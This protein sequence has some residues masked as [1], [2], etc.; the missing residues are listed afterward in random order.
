MLFV[1]NGLRRS[2]TGLLVT[3]AFF[4]AVRF[5]VLAVENHDVFNSNFDQISPIA[6]IVQAL[7]AILSVLLASSFLA[8][9]LGFLSALFLLAYL[10]FSYCL[11]FLRSEGEDLIGDVHI[12]VA[13]A[14]TALLFSM[15]INEL[16]RLY[17]NSIEA[18]VDAA[19]D[20]FERELPSQFR[21]IGETDLYQNIRIESPECLIISLGGVTQI[22]GSAI[23]DV[24]RP[25]NYNTFNFV[26]IL[27]AL[28]FFVVLSLIV[29][30]VRAK[31]DNNGY[32]WLGY[33]SIAVFSVYLSLTA[34]LAV[35]LLATD[36]SAEAPRPGSELQ[37]AL[38][39][40]LPMT[41]VSA[42]AT[43]P[44]NT[45]EELLE[46]RF[47]VEKLR[48]AEGDSPQE[49][50][51][52][53][54]AKEA[55]RKTSALV[56]DVERLR[57]EY[58]Q[59]LR[60][61]LGSAV[62]RYSLELSTSLGEK[63]AAEHFLSLRDWFQGVVEN[64]TVSFSNCVRSVEA[65]R[66]QHVNLVASMDNLK[67]RFTE[68]EQLTRYIEELNNRQTGEELRV[69]ENSIR[70]SERSCAFSNGRFIPPNREDYGTSLGIAGFATGWLL[71]AENLQ[72]A[73]IT[74]LLGFGLLGALLSLFVRLQ[75]DGAAGAPAHDRLKSAG[76]VDICVVV[77]VGFGAALVVY[78]LSYGGLEIVGS[79][80]TGDPNPY[81]VFAAAFSGAT[82]CITICERAKKLISDSP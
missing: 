30:Q 68:D 31:F 49:L 38:E 51:Y 12:V 26:T 54:A 24:L 72:V 27:L 57:S 16:F 45:V 33:A 64:A 77:F 2:L 15:T 46:D 37:A 75:V 9:L 35:P 43:G 58:E 48:D 53:V 61:Q 80:E 56:F 25:F 79:G 10:P 60:S 66:T 71:G 50:Y 6:R 22:L 23:T 32:F 7:D 59:R 29:K 36:R 5:I 1:L 8:I 62:D 81:I 52:L 3:I 82:L 73:L 44:E 63:E 34:I 28:A 13:G 17:L 39:K 4:I 20:L 41:L 78:L 69:L 55:D 76:I 11:K 42:P 19:R 70:S 65:T 40:M 21:C 47:P 74:G 14:V 18:F 67:R